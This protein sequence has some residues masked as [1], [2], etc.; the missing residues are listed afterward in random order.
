VIG[1]GPAGQLL[2]ADVAK[3]SDDLEPLQGAARRIF[4]TDLAAI[5][6][7][8]LF[9]II[10]DG[11]SVDEG[12]AF[13]LGYAFAPK[14]HCVGLQT[15]PRRLLPYGNNPM[16]SGALERVFTSL[17]ELADWIRQ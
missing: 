6:A 12:A 10:L 15:D 11:R 8:Q 7:A 2:L 13:E 9:L 4:E 3:T 17:D 5:A 14:K 16:V 1:T